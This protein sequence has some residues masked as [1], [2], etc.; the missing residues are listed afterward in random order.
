ML[1]LLLIY[2]KLTLRERDKVTRNNYFV[3]RIY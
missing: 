2:L 1:I 3:G